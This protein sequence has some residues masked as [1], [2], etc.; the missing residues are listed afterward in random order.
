M[1]NAEIQTLHE[2]DG[3]P[4]CNVTFDLSSEQL[5]AAAYAVGEMLLERHRGQDL[6][7]DDVLAL[8]ELTSL[9]DELAR[10]AEAQANATVL[11]TLSRLIAF[12]DA[13]DEWVTSRTGRDW[14]RNADE[15]ALPFVGGMLEP[16]ASLRARGLA[17]ALGGSA[18][19][20][21]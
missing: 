7:I 4:V 18:A 12:H 9:R 15:D 8:R 3:A 16:L 21:N 14:L 1:V 19:A 20:S 5:G 6:E 10:L 2:P 13:A 11:M 17:A